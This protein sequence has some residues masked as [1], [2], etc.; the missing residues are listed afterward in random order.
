MKNIDDPSKETKWL[1]RRFG[2]ILLCSMSCLYLYLL[3]VS[4]VFDLNMDMDD[5]LFTVFHYFVSCLYPFLNATMV[6]GFLYSGINRRCAL[7]MGALI[8]ENLLLYIFVTL[9]YLLGYVVKNS[10]DY[11]TYNKL[12]ENYYGLFFNFYFWGIYAH[13]LVVLFYV[14]VA[15]RL[16]SFQYI[17]FKFS[18][19]ISK[20]WDLI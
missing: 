20:L 19:L 3:F 10:V 12:L 7:R 11:E 8:I 4:F 6:I 17:E 2:S 16:K 18:N 9:M 13:I 1:M 14:I 15:K 5:M